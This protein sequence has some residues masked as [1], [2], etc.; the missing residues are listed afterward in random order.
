[1]QVLPAG[2]SAG[3][4]LKKSSGTD[5]NVEWSTEPKVYVAL[6]TQSG[7]DAPVATMLKNTLGGTVVWTFT[8]NEYVGT[9]VGAFPENKTFLTIYYSNDSSVSIYR[10]T[11]NIIIV[12]DPNDAHISEF[13]PASIKIEV[14]P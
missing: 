13:R 11:D 8:P 10:S 6:L 9:L 3:A 1:L 12:S 4:V 2:G 14:Y 5:Y 7:T